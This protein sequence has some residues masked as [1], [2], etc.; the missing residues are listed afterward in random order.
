MKEAQD[1]ISQYKT[2]CADAKSDAA[3]DLL[4]GYKPALVIKAEIRRI[5]LEVQEQLGNSFQ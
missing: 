5:R 1:C 4:P 2:D 3:L